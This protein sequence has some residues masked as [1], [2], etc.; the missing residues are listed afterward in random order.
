MT[1]SDR[2]SFVRPRLGQERRALRAYGNPDRLLRRDHLGCRPE[3]SM[4]LGPWAACIDRL[5]TTHEQAA[6][7]LRDGVAV[8]QGRARNT[9]SRP[10]GAP[11]NQPRRCPHS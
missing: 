6:A 2:G 10:D 11:G 3:T 8:L 9:S 4:E 5:A 1:I 7:L